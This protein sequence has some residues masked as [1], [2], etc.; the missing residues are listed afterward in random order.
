DDGR[1]YVC[2][3]KTFLAFET[4]GTIAWS[5][6]VDYK[7]NVSMAPV[8]GGHGKS[9]GKFS[10]NVVTSYSFASTDTSV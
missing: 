8:H 7:C 2:S 1:I 3:D 10:V 5:I 9:V 6:H 4:N